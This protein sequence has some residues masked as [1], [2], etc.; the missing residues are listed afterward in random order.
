MLQIRLMRSADLPVLVD[1]WVESWRETMPAIDFDARRGWISTVLSDPAHD[2]YV[3]ERSAPLGFATLEGRRLHQLVVASRAKGS[4]IAAALLDAGKSR[5]A[6]GLD[7]EVNR[8]NPRAV[9]FYL[10]HGFREVGAS[11][12]PNSGLPTLKMTWQPPELADGRAGSPAEA[13]GRETP[14]P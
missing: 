1:L 13:A 14:D 7:L 11:S 2:T 10:R 8:D 5:S 6:A 9:A 12:N 4:G 3:A